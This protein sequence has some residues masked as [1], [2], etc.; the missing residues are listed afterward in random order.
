MSH[1]S[2]DKINELLRKMSPEEIE[3]ILASIYGRTVAEAR[4]QSRVTQ[5]SKKYDKLPVEEWPEFEIK[6]DLSPDNF[7]FVFDNEK[8]DYVKKHYPEGLHLG[9][10]TF[11]ELDSN[12]AC[13]SKRTPDETWTVGFAG[14]ISRAILHWVEGKKMT[15]PLIVPCLGEINIMAG[16]HR[17]AVCRA[18]QVDAIPILARQMDKDSLEEIL[19]SLKW[20]YFFV[21]DKKLDQ[22]ED[23]AN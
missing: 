15:P 21:E 22:D 20:E 9:W 11:A 3:E 2:A 18:K 7:H 12:F 14:K 8:T 19:P 13:Y 16:H 10:V 4:E 5:E 1:S 6:W 17:V 23:A